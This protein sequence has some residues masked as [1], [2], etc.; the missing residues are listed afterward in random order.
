MLPAIRSWD[1]AEE[2]GMS[3]GEINPIFRVVSRVVEI[4][5]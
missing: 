2:M 4:W 1:E 3:E 5:V